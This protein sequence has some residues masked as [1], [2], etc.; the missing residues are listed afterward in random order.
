M[1]RAK[2]PITIENGI[3][4]KICIS[5]GM[6]RQAGDFVASKQ[7]K[8]G[9]QGY[10][11]ICQKKYNKEYRDKYY[12]PHKEKLRKIKYEYGLEADDYYKMINNQNNKCIICNR[13]GGKG[14]YSLH[15]DHDHKTRKVR[16]LLCWKCNSALGA[17]NDNI[18]SLKNAIKYIN[19]HS[20]K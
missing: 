11:R 16:G 2:Y 17:F 4:M 7:A 6:K 14:K 9:V 1:K 8:E 20:T 10:C 5:C 19:K 3:P 13:K 12:N 18:T 15:I